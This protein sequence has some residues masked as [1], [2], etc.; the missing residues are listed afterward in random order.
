[1]KSNKLCTIIAI[2]LEKKPNVVPR[3]IRLLLFK[4]KITLI[5]MFINEKIITAIKPNPISAVK[6]R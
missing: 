2:K 5:K 3:I 1:M 4:L 6:W